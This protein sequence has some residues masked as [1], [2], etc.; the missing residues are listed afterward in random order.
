MENSKKGGGI[1]HRR[2]FAVSVQR[3]EFYFILTVNVIL[4]SD[5]HRSTASI[6]LWPMHFLLCFES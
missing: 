5:C 1:L 2:T 4:H 6:N 3:H